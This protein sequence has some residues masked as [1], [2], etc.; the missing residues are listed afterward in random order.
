MKLSY[1]S[2]IIVFYHIYN[3]VANIDLYKLIL[4]CSSFSRKSVFN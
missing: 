1:I 3:F 4:V 2:K